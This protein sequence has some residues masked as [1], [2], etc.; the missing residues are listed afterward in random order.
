MSMPDADPR[1]YRLPPTRTYTLLRLLVEEGE[2][3]A[4]SRRVDYLVD[5]WEREVVLRSVFIKISIIHTHPPFIVIL[6]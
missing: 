5:A 2:Q 4:A 3:D 6:F 1:L